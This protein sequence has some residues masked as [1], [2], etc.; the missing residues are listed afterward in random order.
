MIAGSALSEAKS[1]EGDG[2]ARKPIFSGF[3]IPLC[4]AQ[5]DVMQGGPDSCE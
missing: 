2:C 1:P 5:D 3:F 4:S